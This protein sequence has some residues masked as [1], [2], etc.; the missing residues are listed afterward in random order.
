MVLFI[1]LVIIS[2]AFFI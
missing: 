2:S 1:L